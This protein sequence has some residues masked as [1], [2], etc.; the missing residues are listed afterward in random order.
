MDNPFTTPCKKYIQTSG[1]IILIFLFFLA[2]P[3]TGDSPGTYNSVTILSTMTPEERV[4]QIF[5]PA[6]SPS[7]SN[8]TTEMTEELETMF[9]TIHPGGVI[10]FARD[11][12]AIDQLVTLTDDLQKKGAFESSD[13]HYPLFISIDQEGG[14]IGR[15]PFGPRMPGNMALG[16]AGSEELTYAVA[17]EIGRE[18]ASL[19]I[20]MNFA[21]VLDVETNQDNP[22]IGVR[23]FGGDPHLVADHG[24]AYIRGMQETGI[25]CSG[26]H[27]PGH[28][29]VDVDSHFSLPVENH[30][31]E[32]MDEVELVPFRSAIQSGVDA[33]MTAHIIFPAYDDTITTLPDG[34]EMPIPAT[35]SRPILTGLLREELQFDCLIITDAMMMKAISDNFGT[36]DAAVMAVR[37]GAD[38]ILMPEPVEEA[39]AA[40]LNA[41]QT[42]PE[43]EARVN[44]SV[45]RILSV[46]KQLSGSTA[47][48]ETLDLSDRIQE[49]ESVCLGDEIY[50]LERAAADQ[51]VTL[52]KD[53]DKS[54]PLSV[55]EK[56]CIVVFSPTAAFSDEFVRVFDETSSPGFP[57]PSVI[58]YTDQNNLTEEQ[59]QL[60][61]AAS[62]VVL[63]TLSSNPG[64][65]ADD[66]YI[67]RFS[68][69]LIR[70]A[71]EAGVM[72]IGISLGQPYDIMYM[73]DI[74]VYLATYAGRP[75]GQNLMAAVRAITGEIPI[76][77]T[78]PVTIEDADG[79]VLYPI[80]YGLVG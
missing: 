12:S 68:Q 25:V 63:G 7:G 3:I 5:M 67:P 8:G 60:V 77:G 59:K 29:D 4:G 23:S 73:Q 15:L 27:F 57:Y 33:I 79:N 78:L 76:Q 38:I 46:K 16:A 48:A 20:N 30:D 54:I 61:S 51:A 56:D 34:Q 21:P 40:V 70:F 80:G 74:P 22:V 11:I 75:G 19:G 18:L 69:D 35:L 49:A 58:T 52:V 37:A 72:V 62:Y 41:Y 9:D 66:Y 24:D 13:T 17:R 28:G 2:V 31:R 44:E 36:G 1:L 42:D 43:I 65:R 39:Y 45:I 71:D 55:T 50:A 32:R 47:Q 6:I 14:L 26:K 53:R 10:L 64:H